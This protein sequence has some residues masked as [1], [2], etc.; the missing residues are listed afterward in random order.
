MS[1]FSQLTKEAQVEVAAFS[2]TMAE[3]GVDNATTAQTFDVLTRG[4]GKSTGEA[5]K[6]SAEIT[7]TAQAIGMSVGQMHE[8]FNAALPTLAVYGDKAISV[9][10]GLASA[11]KETGLETSRLLDIASQ[12]DTFESAAESVGRLNGMLGGNYLNSLEMVKMSEDERIRAMI[13]A[14][15]ASGRAF[16][17]LGRFEQKAIAASVGITD[18]AEANKIFGMSLEAYDDMVN[19]SKAG[20]MSQ[21]E[22]AEQAD[23]AR[24]A[25]EKL[26]NLFQSLAIAVQPIISLFHGFLDIILGIQKIMGPFFAPALAAVAGAFILLKVQSMQA[27]TALAMHNRMQQLELAT[28]G[29]GN[30]AR[31][32]AMTAELSRIKIKM[33]LA[34]A[35]SFGAAAEGVATGAKDKGTAST[36]ANIWATDQNITT[37]LG[38]TAANIRGAIAEKYKTLTTKAGTV[39]NWAAFG[40]KLK[41]I[42]ATIARTASTVA[43]TAAETALTVAVYA[44]AAAWGVLKFIWGGFVAIATAVG[45]ALGLT[46]TGATGTATAAVPAAAGIGALAAAAMAGAKGLLLLGVVALMLGGAFA[47]IGLGVKLA[48]DGIVRIAEA[49][50]MAIAVLGGLALLMG[51]LALGAFLLA[52]AGPVALVGMLLLAAGFMAIAFALMFISTED[53]QAVGKI[54]DGFKD[55]GTAA[56][57]IVQVNA[58]LVSLLGT[59]EDLGEDADDFAATMGS[60]SASMWSLSFAMMFLDMERLAK[61]SALFTSLSKVTATNNALTQTAAG[62]SAIADAIDKMPTF[63]TLAF[64][65]L[66][67]DLQDFAEV[68]GA[69]TAPMKATTQFIQTVQK[70][71]DKHIENATKLIDQVVRYADVVEGGTFASAAN[72]F[73]DDLIKV[74]GGGGDDKKEEK[75]QDI[76]LVMDD[77]GRK[78]I[79]SAVQVQLNKKHNVYVNSS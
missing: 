19:K 70:V 44:G 24:T 27:T 53:L 60:I 4:L 50:G 3:L 79:A 78:V 43:L 29:A 49:G 64:S 16:N 17:Q 31:V 32:T 25:Q 39:A 18:M 28:M 21:E 41:N 55:L 33:G 40:V 59:L 22:M 72:N 57:N 14:T 67:E 77:A 12:F 52:K 65:W 75:T 76:Y 61:V 62:I 46:A 8:A 48:A 51:S 36:L 13:E 47:L 45:S 2:A 10:Q 9:F 30:S 74:L 54:F 20:A 56:E 5:M 42:G 7:K 58:S 26:Q 35:V 11:A 1:Q 69:V 38:E 23:K 63:G 37:K 73:L 71:E 6:M 15:Q 34:S 66:L 68:G